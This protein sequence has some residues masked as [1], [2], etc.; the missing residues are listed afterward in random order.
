M[1]VSDD[2]VMA[3]YCVAC[4]RSSVEKW[5]KHIFSRTH[6]QTTQKFLLQQ[7]TRLQ[8]F[9]NVPSDWGHCVFCDATLAMANAPSHFGCESHRKQVEAFC[10]KHRCDA[11]RQLR[12]QLWLN[13]SKRRQLEAAVATVKDSNLEQEI[14]LEEKATVGQAT[15]KHTEAFLSSAV[16]RLQDV[17]HKR[18]KTEHEMPVKD[19]M[20]PGQQIRQDGYIKHEHMGTKSLGFVH[21][22]TEFAQGEGLSSIAPV[23]WGATV[24]NVHTG[25]IPP[26][27][28]ETEDEYKQCNQREQARTVSSTTNLKTDKKRR[29]VLTELRSKS[30]Y[31]SDWLPNFGGVWQEG[32][33]SKTKQAFQK[34]TTVA[35]FSRSHVL[36]R[37][38]EA[39]SRIFFQTVQSQAVPPLPSPSFDSFLIP[40]MTNEESQAPIRIPL[41]TFS[42]QDT[43]TKPCESFD[44]KKALL[45]AQRDRLRA[46]LAATKRSK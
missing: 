39:P 4:R 45:L 32:P 38:T 24:G 19:V 21:R 7:V 40:T 3:P 2:V 36:T 17:R 42:M 8:A 14:Q 29:G 20:T 9:C 34:P 25:A 1:V 43:T 12:P 35:K 10:R 11:N 27:M 18:Q 30:E 41:E 5:R 22:V 23:R 6:Q 44:E 26:W 13:A 15:R 31:T 37:P 33:R 46:K 16:S 28:V